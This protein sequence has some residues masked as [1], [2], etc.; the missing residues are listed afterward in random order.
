MR[1]TS[2]LPLATESRTTPEVRLKK[3]NIMIEAAKIAVGNPDEDVLVGP[4][5]NA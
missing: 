5:N 2:L 4:V 3:D 1:F